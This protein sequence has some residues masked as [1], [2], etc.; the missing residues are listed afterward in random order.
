[1]AA[2]RQGLAQRFASLQALFARAKFRTLRVSW[3]ARQRADGE[4]L[5]AIDF[6]K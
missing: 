4:L 2:A 6:H 5:S 3:S 1:V